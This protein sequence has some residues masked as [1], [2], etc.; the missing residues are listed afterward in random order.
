MI[1]LIKRIIHKLLQN[2]LRKRL[3]QCGVKV[4]IDERF[5]VTG[6]QNISLGNSVYIGPNA[7]LMASGAH[8]EIKG[9]LCQ[10][11]A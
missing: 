6:A 9:H 11:L 4:Y 10:V 3:K 8:I 5:T 7:T 1:I 2:N